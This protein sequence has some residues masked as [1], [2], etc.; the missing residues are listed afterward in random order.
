MSKYWQQVNKSKDRTVIVNSNS[1]F[2]LDNLILTKKT[3]S[4]IATYYTSD[5]SLYVN[6]TN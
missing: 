3:R 5:L 1:M 2:C 4:I 6:I